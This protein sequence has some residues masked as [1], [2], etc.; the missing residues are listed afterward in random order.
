[1]ISPKQDFWAITT[2]FNLAN[3]STRFSNYQCFRR[4]L[5]IPLLTVEWHPAGT[6]QLKNGDADLLVQISGGDL[7]W[8][9]ERLLTVAIAS[10]PDQV[11]Y[12]AWVDCDILF[13]NR[14]W[15]H[16]AR[17]LLESK[18]VIQ[19]FG[20]V[21]FPNANTSKSLAE[22]DEENFDRVD[23]EQMSWRESFLCMF[24]RLKEDVVRF[25][26]ER[27]FQQDQIKN[28][29]VLKRPAPGFAWAAPSAFLRKN[30]V[31]DR[32][33]MGG[34]DMLFCYGITGLSERL[35][36]NHKAAGWSFYG[37]CPSYR[38]WALH[39]AEECRGRLGFVDGRIVHLFHGNLQDRQYKS[40]I[41]GLVPFAV[42]LDRDIAA[43]GDGPWYWRRDQDRLNRYFYEYIRNRNEG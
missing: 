14:D 26:L 15:M 21:A 41:D 28:C 10:L 13:E 5:N 29:N 40:R 39:V 2:Y 18:S 23:I 11:K 25:D 8:Q 3:A 43:P 27:R 12:V 30:G 33:I 7:M 16:E 1:M 17:K 36:D 20:D 4:R 34:G 32:C 38:S 9:K 19:L 37:D 31:Y 6:F 35:L 24:A 22:S 42:D